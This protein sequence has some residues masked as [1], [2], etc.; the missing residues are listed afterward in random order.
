MLEV[1]C[2]GKYGSSASVG[3]VLPPKAQMLGRQDWR[4]LSGSGKVIRA[5]H[6]PN[7]EISCLCYADNGI[8]LASRSCDE[9]LKVSS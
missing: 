2:A 6:Q 1:M 7:Q 4:F 3:Q 5:A 9:T 8:M